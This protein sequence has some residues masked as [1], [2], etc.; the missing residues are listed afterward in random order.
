MTM[1]NRLFALP[2]L[3]SLPL[4]AA[5]EFRRSGHNLEVLVDG[6]LFT[7]YRS[8]TRVPCLYPL[9]GP[10]GAALTRHF[11]FKKDVPGEAADHPHHLSCWFTHGL[12]NG[13]DFWHKKD[14]RIVHKKFAA[15]PDPPAGSNK[16]SFTVLL[17]WTAGNK[18][19]LRERRTYAFRVDDTRRSIEVASALTPVDSDVLFGDTKEGSFALRLAPTLRLKGKVAKGHI[20]NSENLTDEQV[21]GKRAK[22]VAYHGPDP[23]GEPVVVAILDH[24]GNLRHPAWWHARDYGLLAA[25]PFGQHHFEKKK[26]PRLGDYTLQKGRTLALRYLILLHHGDFPT[27]NI[28]QAWKSFASNQRGKPH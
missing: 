20:R 21:W 1:R 10:S 28:D 8:D 25:N 22:W 5:L 4:H 3:L 17:E 11:P 7:E 26:N 16:A 15:L 12:V 24:P 2:L 27:A 23:N 19:V 9:I 13:H 18:P 14:C 6:K